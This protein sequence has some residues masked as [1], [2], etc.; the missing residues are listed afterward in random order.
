VFGPF[1]AAT[2]PYKLSDS[3]SRGDAAEPLR[4][5]CP[6]EPRVQAVPLTL[7]LREHFFCGD[8]AEIGRNR[9]FARH[10]P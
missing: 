4:L 1:R 3:K 8:R 2:I 7:L 10:A 6:G 9:P 5:A